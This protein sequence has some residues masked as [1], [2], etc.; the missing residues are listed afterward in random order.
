M[1]QRITDAITKAIISAAESLSVYTRSNQGLPITMVRAVGVPVNTTQSVTISATVDCWVNGITT[2][3]ITSYGSQH[4][5]AV[6]AL[7]PVVDVVSQQL[8]PLQLVVVLLR[9]AT[10]R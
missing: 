10:H 3:V 6:T 7:E 1:A 5:A 9:N 4:V 8:G 2:N